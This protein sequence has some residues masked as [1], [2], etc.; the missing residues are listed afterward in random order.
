M[1]EKEKPLERFT[2]RTNA[3]EGAGRRLRTYLLGGTAVIGVSALAVLGWHLMPEATN[4]ASAVGKMYDD[5]T[6]P[7]TTPSPT[8]TP[9]SL[10]TAVVET[11]T[12][13]T[14]EKTKPAPTTTTKKPKPKQS[15]ERTVDLTDS[16]TRH[17]RLNCDRPFELTVVS[18]DHGVVVDIPG[19]G[20]VESAL[21][22][23]ALVQDKSPSIDIMDLSGHTVKRGDDDDAERHASATLNGC[24][25]SSSA[26]KQDQGANLIVSVKPA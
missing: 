21:G 14:P 13:P 12:T 8:V 11:Q 5:N 15:R 24:H 19:I 6:R 3:Y 16:D 26:T 1:P 20:S 4:A 7:S 10:P 22:I 17:V 9:S 25:I 18:P 2:G 23:F